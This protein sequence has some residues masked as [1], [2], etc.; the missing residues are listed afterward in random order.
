[1]RIKV[2]FSFI[3]IINLLVSCGSPGLNKKLAGEDRYN[4][5]KV[6]SLLKKIL[7]AQVAY[8]SANGAYG[9]LNDL[10]RFNLIEPGIVSDDY[11]GYKFEMENAQ[12]AYKVLAL[13][14]KNKSYLHSFYLDDT[15][16]I[17]L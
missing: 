11:F 10:I 16:V 3:I 2:C 8:Q 1:M 9:S 15:G 6:V 17:R 4:Q 12:G 7:Q 5:N 14:V 13:P